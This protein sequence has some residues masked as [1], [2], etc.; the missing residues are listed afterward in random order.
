MGL[1]TLWPIFSQTHLV[2]VLRGGIFYGRCVGVVNRKSAESSL[3]AACLRYFLQLVSRHVSP[4]RHL[5]GA[6]RTDIYLY[7]K[8]G[9]KPNIFRS[10][11]NLRTRLGVKNYEN[12]IICSPSSRDIYILGQYLRKAKNFIFQ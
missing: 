5:R 6:H 3:K 12:D 11:L 7:K 9:V 1:A 4:H 10:F 2:T 8:A